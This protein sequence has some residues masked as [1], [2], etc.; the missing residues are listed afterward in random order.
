MVCCRPRSTLFLI[1]SP[2]QEFAQGP[3]PQPPDYPLRP[4]SPRPKT[5][6]TLPSRP[7]RYHCDHDLRSPRWTTRRGRDRLLRPGPLRLAQ[8]VPALAQRH[9]LPGPL[10]L[11]LRAPGPASVPALLRCLDRGPQ[12][13][14]RPQ[15][16]RSGR[17]GPARRIA[18]TATPPCTWSAPG[19]GRTTGRSARSPWPTNPTKSRRSHAGWTSWT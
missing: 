17:E 16:G 5:R 12:Q 7:S 19:P 14:H 11:R 15:A 18:R 2:D 13:G 9:S 8:D 6:T 4:R 1:P 10:P 3:Q